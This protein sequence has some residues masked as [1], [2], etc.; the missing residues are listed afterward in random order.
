M[1]GQMLEIT[2]YVICGLS[3]LLLILS[4]IIFRMR[5]KKIVN[6]VYE[7]LE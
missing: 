5:K 4:E 3:G 1:S 7:R 2:G 6:K